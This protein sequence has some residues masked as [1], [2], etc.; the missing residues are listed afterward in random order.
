MEPRA[1]FIRGF[2]KGMAAPLVLFSA[3]DLP[4]QAQPLTFRPLT[5]RSEAPASDW[6]RVGQALRAAAAKD[7]AAGG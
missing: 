6:L 1:A 3:L 2:W 4:A 5:R 7:R